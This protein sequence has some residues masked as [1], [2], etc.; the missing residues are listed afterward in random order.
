[1]ESDGIHSENTYVYNFLR[2]YVVTSLTKQRNILQISMK[3]NG[4]KCHK[5][6]MNGIIEKF[7]VK[8]VG[9]I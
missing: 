6:I 3:N 8:T 7:T 2:P 1:M 9:I 4:K 5:R